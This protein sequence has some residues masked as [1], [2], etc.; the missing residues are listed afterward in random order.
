MDELER[1]VAK[2]RYDFHVAE[3]QAAQR[4]QAE[5][6]KWLLASLVLV[7]GGAL[8]LLANEKDHAAAA[9]AAPAFIVG[10]VAA[11]LCGFLGWLNAGV[12]DLHYDAYAQPDSL[13]T[14]LVTKPDLSDR[15]DWQITWS[16][17]LSIWMGLLSIGAFVW[18]AMAAL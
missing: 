10:I 17:R 8:V 5:L 2:A 3:S 6:A 12:R 11:I 18:G 14:G 13:K 1:E 4:Y 16:Y 9:S 7:N 15:R